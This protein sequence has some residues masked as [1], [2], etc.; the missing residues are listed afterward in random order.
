ML[1]IKNLFCGYQGIDIIRDLSLRAEPGEVLCIVGPN[2]CGKTTLLKSIARIIL[3]RGKI[4][5][6]GREAA[7]YSRK[8]LARRI[9]LLG[10]NSELYF[11]Y[12]VYDTVALGRY[13]HSR[14]FLKGLSREDDAVIG[15]ILQK[16]ELYGEK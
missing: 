11:P 3:Y 1:E 4:I 7:S 5:L 9:A 6:D 14:G 10:Q 16:L 8:E 13:A 12:T 2:G 15:D